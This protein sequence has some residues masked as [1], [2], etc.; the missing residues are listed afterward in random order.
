[1]A[2]SN[3]DHKLWVVNSPVGAFSGACQD[4]MV[5]TETIAKQVPAATAS[6]GEPFTYT[7]T[8]PSMNYPAGKSATRRPTTLGT[9]EVRTISDRTDGADLSIVKDAS[10]A[11]YVL[12]AY[13]QG[14]AQ[15]CRS[16]W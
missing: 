13:V 16:R 7:L 1:M 6:I 14:T 9:I 11:S 10:K 12:N 15:R 3:I 2:C 5:P 4:L 8:L